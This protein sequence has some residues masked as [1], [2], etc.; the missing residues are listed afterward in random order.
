MVTDGG[1]GGGAYAPA[2]PLPHYEGKVGA[3]R[4]AGTSARQQH[5][6]LV[7]VQ[8]GLQSGGRRASENVTGLLV[9][10]ATTSTQVPRTKAGDMAKATLLAGGVMTGFADSIEAYNGIVDGLN[11]QYATAKGN[12]FGV[13]SD[14]GATDDMSDSE[15]QSAHRD[16][17][18]AADRALRIELGAKER[19]A[20]VELDDMGDTFASQLKNGPTEETMLAL[21]LA[22]HID[23]SEALPYIGMTLAQFN[24]VRGQISTVRT[25][26]KPST[27]KN[28][29]NL[30][31][32]LR[33]LAGSGK[34]NQSID[35]Q[36][37]M[38]MRKI[39]QSAWQK[40]WPLDRRLGA[41]KAGKIKAADLA[42]YLRGLPGQNLVDGWHPGTLAM[43]GKGGFFSSSGRIGSWLSRSKFGGGV[44]TV[45]GKALGPLGLA[46]GVYTVGDTIVNWSDKS[47][48]D[49]VTGLVGG[50]SSAISGGIATAALLGVSVTP[51]GAAIA[52]TAGAIA[53]GT[54]AYQHREQIADGAKWVFDHS[55]AGAVWNHRDEIIDGAGK[56]VDTAVDT[57][58]DIGGGIKDGVTGGLKKIGLF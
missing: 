17:V 18:D 58:K 4:T 25:I 57:V 50:T 52:V 30:A 48:E 46:G 42:K 31:K 49:K 24:A 28:Y 55:P 53:L 38:L 51:V 12:G 10:P 32:Y 27:Y 13:A 43:D 34:L 15:K 14:A 22:G 45:F 47:T 54:F 1:G 35:I 29:V 41:F 37:A 9:A 21:T 2:F 56:A 8:Q 33:T 23:V 16:A 44:N 5:G 3:T 11:A 6:P 26:L 20:R 39:M 40:G 19:Q 7:G 36:Q